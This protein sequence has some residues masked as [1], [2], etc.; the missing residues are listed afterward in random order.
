M[1]KVR[2]ED[3]KKNKYGGRGGKEGGEKEEILELG[4][5]DAGEGI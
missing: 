4:G 2:S 1:K 5:G 3:K